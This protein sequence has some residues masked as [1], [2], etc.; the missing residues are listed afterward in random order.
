[1][2]FKKNIDEILFFIPARG[3]S[4][5]IPG[6][7][8]IDL[9]G[10]PMIAYVIEKIKEFTLNMNLVNCR[11]IVSTNDE[12]IKFVAEEYGAEVPFLRPNDLSGDNSPT[13]DSI[14]Y[15]INKLLDDDLYKPET[16]ILIQPT[17]PFIA[18]EDIINAYKLFKKY[19]NPVV[20]VVK[21]EHPIEWSY[22]IENKYLKPIFNSKSKMRQNYLNSYRLNGALYISDT[23]SIFE[24]NGF[25]SDEV[26]PFRMP[27]DR[28][29]DIDTIWDLN[30][31][32][33]LLRMNNSE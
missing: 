14:L 2:K 3:G 15:T 23:K 29:I 20:S 28:S 8:I 11:I 26:R 25:F 6:K 1:M 27:L 24:N 17:S 4:K 18:C 5:S 16:I 9:G 13:I 32:R 7:N 31:A 30:F 10:K 19:D 33:T 21:N 22:R 12:K